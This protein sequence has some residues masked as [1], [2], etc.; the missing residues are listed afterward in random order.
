M[1]NMNDEEEDKY[2]RYANIPIPT[3]DEALSR[4]S[5]SQHQHRGP[6]EISDDAERED[7]LY[8][9]PTV[10]SA[11]SSLDS[12]LGLP[13]VSGADED[14]ARRV[15]EELDYME[16]TPDRSRRSPRP[17]YRTRIR[18][19]LSQ[20]WFNLSATLSAIR[21]PRVPS[22]RS[23]Y[24]AV[25]DQSA[26][27]PAVDVP[28]PS[29]LTW[30]TRT[31]QV[32]S[33]PE[34]YRMSASTFARLC[35]LFA[36]G[37][38]IYVLFALDV[39]PNNAR[40]LY[41]AG[42]FDPESIRAFVTQR[43]GN[44]LHPLLQDITAA[45]HVA[46][47]KGDLYIVAQKMERWFA[48]KDVFDHIDLNSYYVYMNYPGGRSVS[49]VSPAGKKWTAT[50]EED[51]VENTQGE[52]AY[53]GHS[54][55][56]EV[57]GHL[58]YANTGSREE[59]AAL[60][61]R[62]VVLEGSIV[63][64]KVSS[65]DKD[66]AL[67]VRAA[68]QA[69]CAGI[70]IY[71]DP[72]DVDESKIWRRPDDSLQ[73]DGVSMTSWVLGDPLTP[74]VAST[75]DA[76]RLSASNNPALPSI[77]SLP[78]AWR[79]AQVLLSSLDGHGYRVDNSWA[80]GPADFKKEWWSGNISTAEDPDVSVVH[81]KNQNDENPL[82]AIWNL[83]G[84]I[85]GMETPEKKIIVGT[86]RDVW[87]VGAIESGVS[88]AILVQ[89]VRIFG[90]LRQQSWRPLR[91]I[92]FV[93]WDASQVGLMGSSEYVEDNLDDLRANAVAYINVGVGITGA[94]FGARGSPLF[95][96]SLKHILSQTQ[97][98]GANGTIVDQWNAAHRELEKLDVNGDYAP[99][100]HMAGTSS[101]DLGFHG[102]EFGYP[103]H[104]CY[105]TLDFLERPTG[106]FED[107]DQYSL[108]NREVAAKSLAQI[109]ALMILEIADRPI[110]PFDVRTYALVLEEYI[111]DLERDAASMNGGKPPSEEQFNLTPLQ[112][113]VTLL[114]TNADEFHKF[115]NVWTA[116][117][118]GSGGLETAAYASKRV[119]FNER[120]SHFETT[121]LDIPW[122]PSDKPD[123][124]YG[125]PGREQFKHVVY[126]PRLWGGSR[127]AVSFPMIKDAWDRSPPDWNGA[128]K[129]LERTAWRIRGAAEKLIE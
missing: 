45:D 20:R 80:H 64:V 82:Q 44:G 48:E 102:S 19:K 37:L 79:D 35:G 73:R 114:G 28:A 120:L 54:R 40:N 71:S 59:F 42:R 5:S 49:I 52:L 2:R 123:D 4:P 11:R 39:F 43:V 29:R 85:D 61:E 105:D 108:A 6:R 78:L 13:E 9:R 15:M 55:S 103:K 63:L 112:D 116:N 34:K 104:S 30:L 66:A 118:L 68:E 106:G 83:H 101:L 111:Q 25:P 65:T 126:G 97:Q 117:V 113:A 96:D 47:T 46:G 18:S 38:L 124:H 100:Q 27:T 53:H 21:L 93:S 31:A 56:A 57:E 41:G 22:L 86:H 125:I 121:L 119:R 24:A 3:Y 10:E 72:S 81:V 33:I 92:E 87:C 122:G 107:H 14:D 74:G 115:E 95:S 62:G 99:F 109:W 129:A 91:T 16:D 26:P 12:D 36:I 17:Y 76:E 69:G 1:P 89:L 23:L 75:K 84:R 67:Q 70:L 50:L 51:M 77:P 7:L 94:D 110:I 60:R 127:S 32:V 90:E 8:R 128:Q 98:P 88:S 58:V